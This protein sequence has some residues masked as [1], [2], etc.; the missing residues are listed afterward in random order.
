MSSDKDFGIGCF[1]ICL[2]IAAI[3][4]AMNFRF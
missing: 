3:I 1:F 2:G 4:L